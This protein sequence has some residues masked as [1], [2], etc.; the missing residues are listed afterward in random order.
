MLKKTSPEF[1]QIYGSREKFMQEN[2]HLPTQVAHNYYDTQLKMCLAISNNVEEKALIHE[3]NDYL[4]EI[5]TCD[6]CD[7]LH[8]F[9]THCA[10]CLEEVYS[11]DSDE[12][13]NFVPYVSTALTERGDK[14]HEGMVSICHNCHQRQSERNRQILRIGMP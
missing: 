6:S 13:Y 5:W 14:Y 11:E 12:E 3:E 7:Q 4:L 2:S 10:L 9:I 8:Y 1:V